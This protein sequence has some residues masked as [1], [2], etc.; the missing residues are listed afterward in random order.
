M[1]KSLGVVFFLSAIA[2]CGCVEPLTPRCMETG[3][4]VEYEIAERDGDV[5]LEWKET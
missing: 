1:K 2:L 4:I 3:E 5:V